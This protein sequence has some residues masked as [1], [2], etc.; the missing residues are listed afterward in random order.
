MIC[1][2]PL[3]MTKLMNNHE[4]TN[5]DLE[6]VEECYKILLDAGSDPFSICTGVIN[7]GAFRMSAFTD[8]LLGGTLVRCSCYLWFSLDEAANRH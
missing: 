6:R 1:S 4:A 8:Q 5:H 2:K 3:D 7:I